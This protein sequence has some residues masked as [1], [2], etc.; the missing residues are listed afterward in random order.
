MKKYPLGIFFFGG[1]LFLISILLGIFN[2]L[3]WQEIFLEN[4]SSEISLE[5]SEISFFQFVFYFFLSTLIFLIFCSLSKKFQKGKEGFLKILFLFVSIF[6]MFYFFSPLF[7]LFSLPLVIFLSY[8]WLKKRNLF[9]NNLCFI[10]GMAGIGGI[11]GLQLKTSTLILLLIFLSIYD[12]LAVYKTRHMVRMA[13]EMMET[14]I[15]LGLIIPPK[16]SD[17]KIDL[18]K[19][20]FKGR[21][22]ILGGGDV[23]FP[24]MFCANLTKINLFS[25]LIVAFFS[26]F[27][28][29]L[30]FYLLSKQKT[31]HP[32]PALPSLSFFLIIGY[33]LTFLIKF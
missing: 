29:F 26:L 24:L 17:L 20:E 13:S 28:L 12:F 4:K 33:L 22:L 9:L 5:S 31:S 3:N 18:R 25:A 10:L 32:L 19:V 21:F 16:I 7:D 14:K 6:G 11:L 23:G 1:S 27:G 15:I 8:L 30:N 2:A